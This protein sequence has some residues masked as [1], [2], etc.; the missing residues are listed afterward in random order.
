MKKCEFTIADKDHWDW[1]ATKLCGKK[2]GW[3]TD[4]GVPVCGVHKRT[5]DRFYEKT[6]ETFRCIPIED[7]K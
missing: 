6:K 2:A 7:E 3:I 5:A 1:D 4:K